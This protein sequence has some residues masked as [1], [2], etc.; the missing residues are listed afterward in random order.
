MGPDIGP[1]AHLVQHLAVGG[2][3]AADENDRI[4]AAGEIRQTGLAIRDLPADRIVNGHLRSIGVPPAHL[5]GQR[6]EQRNAL[7]G[8]RKEID[9][10]R[11]VDSFKVVRPLDHNRRGLDLTGQPDHFGMS[12]LSDLLQAQSELQEC[13]NG[14]ID[15]CI[16]YRTAL[17]AYMNRAGGQTDGKTVPE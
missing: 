2:F 13:S 7:C 9:R 14:Y 15:Q 8:L 10:T 3:A 1:A 4:E 6:L 5:A 11:E 17:Q 12:P 16:A